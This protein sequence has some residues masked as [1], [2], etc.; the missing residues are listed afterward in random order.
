MASVP[1][2]RPPEEERAHGAHRER[3]R[4]RDGDLGDLGAKVLGDRLDREDEDEEV[5]RVERPAEQAGDERMALIDREGFHLR[6]EAGRSD[7]GG[8]RG[9]ARG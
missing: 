3:E 2:G 4:D 1:V 7:R 5:E 6:E 8:G 9:H